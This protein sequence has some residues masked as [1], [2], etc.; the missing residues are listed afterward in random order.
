[1]VAAMLA[2]TV[3]VGIAA[4]AIIRNPTMGGLATYLRS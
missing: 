1:V 3:W 4:A 2:L